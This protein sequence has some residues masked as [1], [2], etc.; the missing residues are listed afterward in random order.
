MAQ[1]LQELD[2]TM[3]FNKGIAQGLR[4]GVL[5]EGGLGKALGLVSGDIVYEILGMTPTSTEQRIA[6]YQA[7]KD[8]PVGSRFNVKLI[9]QGQEVEMTYRSD[10]TMLPELVDAIAAAEKQHVSP[11]QV[12]NT[13][14]AHAQQ[15]QEP[16]DKKIQD[17]MKHAMSTHQSS[18]DTRVA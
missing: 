8:L 4:I 16:M 11:E 10:R 1:L 18:L 5:P 7:L 9:R 3:A 12:T 13:L 2:I 14:V 15:S 17:Q 6:I